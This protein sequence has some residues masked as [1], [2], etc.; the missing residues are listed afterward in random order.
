ML[1]VEV[2]F[3]RCIGQGLYF[4]L[5]IEVIVCEN[6]NCSMCSMWIVERKMADSTD[7]SPWMTRA[8]RYIMNSS[9]FVSMTANKNSVID[10]LALLDSLENAAGIIA[11]E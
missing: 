5:H 4:Y 6:M 11:I 9:H 2:V 1:S 10:M 7:G 3:S 8:C